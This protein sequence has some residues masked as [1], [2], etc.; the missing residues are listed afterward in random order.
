MLA[1]VMWASVAHARPP[2]VLVILSDDQR[3]DTIHALGNQEI[4]TPAL[5]SLV[6]RGTVFDRAYCMGS[7]EQAVCVPSRA[8]LLSGRSLFRVATNLSDCDTWPEQFERAG[9]RTFITG[10]WHNGKPA[11]RRCFAEGDAVFL[12][13]MHDQWAVPTI[14]FRDHGEPTANE[15]RKVHSTE[16]FGTA[17]ERFVERL[18]DEPFF[19]WVSFTSPHDPRQA[20]DEFRRRWE[21]RDLPPPANYLPE[22]PFD[23][24][25]MQSR[26]EQLLPRPRTKAAVSRSLADYYACVEG[27]DDRIGRLLAALEAK[28]RLADTLILFTSDHGLAIGSHGLLGKQNLYEHSMRSPAIIAGPGVPAGKRCA[29]L[30][31]LFDLTATIGALANVA[32][33]EGNEGRSLVPVVRGEQAGIRESLLL[34]YRDV[35]RALVTPAWKLIEYPQAGRTQLFDLAADPGEMHDRSGDPAEAGRLA[36]LRARLAAAREQAAVTHADGP[37]RSY[38][39]R[40]PHLAMSNTSGECGVGAVVPW[41]DRLWVITYAP[42]ARTGSDDKLYEIDAHL[43][44]TARPESVGGTP[45]ARF[46]HDPTNQLVIGPYVIDAKRRVHAVSPTKMEGR[47]SAASRHPS[48][49]EGKALVYDMEGLLYEL[50]MK[51]HE[52]K[53]LVARAAPGWHGKGM[54][55]GQDVVVV[56]NNGEHDA[57]WGLK[58]FEPFAYAIANTRASK[59]EAGVLAEWSPAAGAKAWRLIKRRQFT[60][61]TGPGGI[62]GPPRDDAPLWAI[63]WDEKS[64]LLLVRSARDA[65]AGRE[66]WHTFRMPK[67]CNSF[68]GD[69]G[70]HTEWPRIREVVPAANGKPAKF[71]LTM[72]GGW[73]DFPGTF[74]AESTGGIRPLC[75]HLKIT[76]DV[77]PWTL[78]GKPVIAF[79]CDDAAKSGFM[80]EE[81]NPRNDLTGRSNSNLWFTSWEGLATLGRPAGTG[82]VWRR[83]DVKAGVASDPLLLAGGSGYGH[84]VVHL[85]H[86]SDSPVTFTLTAGA[87]D[88]WRPIASVTVPPRGYAFSVLPADVAGDWVRVALDRDA[89]GVTAVFRYGS[90]GGMQEE[91]GVFAALA[92][93]GSRE[94]W[95]AAALR[96]G[97]SGSLPLEVLARDVDAA[98]RATEAAT[99]R[100]AVGTAP[101]PLAS[102]DPAAVLLRDKTAPTSPDV[103]FDAGSVILIEGKKVFRLPKPLDPAIAAAYE[104]PFATGWPRGLREV[105]TERSL[106]NAAGTFYVL[107]RVTSGGAAKIQPVCSHGKRITDFCS[108]RGL[109]VLGGVRQQAASETF[110]GTAAVSRVIGSSDPTG[111][112]S[113]G[114]AVWVG[115]I[116]ELWKLPRPTGRG[117]PWHE[118]AVQAGVPSDPYLMGGYDTKTLA[119]SHDAGG[120][121]S[122]TIEVD[123]TGDGVWFPYASISVPAGSPAVHRFPTGFLA[124]WVRFTTDSA[125]RATAVLTYE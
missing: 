50:D 52:P 76:G 41:A 63:G 81:Q 79:G 61:V 111:A 108:W 112:S 119:L 65:A 6:A 21:Q 90:R 78:D 42:H 103:S 19:A 28:G 121:V 58:A 44:L 64:V 47:L 99:W 46:I 122:V 120:P 15:R 98:G 22:H 24:G 16:L 4:R 1:G 115:D 95:V 25:E 66:P 48:D 73:Y 91:P 86:E 20:P 96:T 33:P 18:G 17:A 59:D 34:A 94:P 56:A 12:G 13:G 92:D 77:A 60:D 5:D 14:S 3:T 53:L 116:D 39:G 101:E 107:P 71:I 105:V 69:H 62:H 113:R 87:G 37:P 83:E 102:G 36:D 7:M 124:Q 125:C 84:R 85:A 10:K 110:A 43:R 40:Y 11:V 2:S 82:Y 118:T 123:P 57:K 104:K 29:A 31:Y 114:P 9:Y 97:T 70:W 89:A 38:G 35:Q 32:P 8:M 54:Y 109:L 75:S 30:A 93:V 67:A 27:M 106:L 51:T 100:V 45:A 74:S 72:H 23:N 80:S 68:D 26:D 55:A 49:P 88:Q 117:G